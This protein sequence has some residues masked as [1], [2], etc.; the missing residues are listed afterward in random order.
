MLNRRRFVMGGS[1]L[2]LSLALGLPP[3]FAQTPYPA[4][5]M[6][7]LVP[8]PAGSP[9][10]AIAR[11]LAEILVPRLG[12]P[13][14]IDNKPGAVGS[15]AAAEVARASADG[16]TLLFTTADA[17]IGALAVLK[18]LPYD[19]RKDFA[20]ISK[21]ASNGPVLVAHP[22]VKASNLPELIA[23]IKGGTVPDAYGS[24]GP[25]TLPAQVMESMA[26]QAKVKLTEV[27]YRGSPP[28]LQD[29]L[30]N[31][32]GL[33][34]TG[35]NVAAPL[36]A[37]GK[38]KAL[39]VVGPKRSPLLPDVQTFSEAGFKGFVF[40]NE[41]WAGLLAPAMVPSAV[42]D[43]LAQAV[44]AAVR[45]PALQ[46]YLAEAGFAALGN[47]PAEF[48]QQYAAEVAVVPPLIREMG[49]APQ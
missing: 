11:K 40:T 47:T 23:G 7:W 38:I 10:D 26:R 45:E 46:K 44:Q 41:I 30:G 35:P 5:P 21:V 48:A 1:A 49:V 13:I 33:T 4:K 24:W 42:R 28:A 27:P 18:S 16:Y 14:V 37:D 32:I 3:S 9:I 34:F 12:Q 2:P 15:I 19:P 25:G 31:Q 43:Q 17:L 39:A 36:I 20:F 6:R 29:L 8:S 22:S